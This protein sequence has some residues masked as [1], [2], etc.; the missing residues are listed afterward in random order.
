MVKRRRKLFALVVPYENYEF[1]GSKPIFCDKRSPIQ[2][3]WFPLYRG[4]EWVGIHGNTSSLSSPW[5][6][7]NL[8]NFVVVNLS[9]FEIRGSLLVNLC[10]RFPGGLTCVVQMDLWAQYLR[11]SRSTQKF[12]T[13]KFLKIL[14]VVNQ[15][16][17]RSDGAF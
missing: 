10:S 12:E 17:L 3:S 11:L 7:A 2:T 16:L 15:L 5:F 13:W 8:R 14:M 9:L 4:K 6:L 1:C